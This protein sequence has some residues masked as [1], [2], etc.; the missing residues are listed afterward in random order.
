MPR[1]SVICATL[2]RPSYAALVA[3]VRRQT[4]RDFEFIGRADPGNEYIAR[5]RAAARATGD[6]LVFVDDDAILRPEHLA[7]LEETISLT[8]D[9]VAVSGALQGNMMGQGVVVLSNP[10]WWVGANMAVRR[11]VFLERPFEEDWGLGHTPKGWRADTD[12]GFSIEERY[13]NRWTHDGK[14]IV[15]HPGQMGSA[16]QPEVEA[17][18][19]RRWRSKV[20]DRFIS[21]DFRL[22]QFLLETQDLSPDERAKVLSARRAMRKLVPTLPMLSQES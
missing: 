4:F 18:F 9:V 2:L 7:R 22:Q 5:N 13:P 20:I 8:P 1:F 14:W 19:F 17:V 15:D 10:G 12:L 3:S 11:D 21:V 6:W 16:F